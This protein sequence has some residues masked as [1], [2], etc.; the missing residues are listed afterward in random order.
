[1]PKTPRLTYMIVCGLLIQSATVDVFAADV[2]AVE[3]TLVAGKKAMVP[4]VIGKSAS[5]DVVSVTRE[6]PDVLLEHGY[7]RRRVRLRDA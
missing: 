2:E 6:N 3:A 7:R 5:D 1:M 4:I